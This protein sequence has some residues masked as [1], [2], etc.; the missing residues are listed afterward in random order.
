MPSA[1]LRDLRK[2]GLLAKFTSEKFVPFQ[3]RPQKDVPLPISLHNIARP[4][5]GLPLFTLPRAPTL[6]PAHW[7]PAHAASKRQ[8]GSLKQ[9]NTILY[10]TILY[11]TIPYHTIL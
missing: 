9:Y 2:M 4:K 1:R 11:Y 3:Q 5:V 7:D 10:Y 6:G 8:A